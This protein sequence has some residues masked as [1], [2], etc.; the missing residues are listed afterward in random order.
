[1]LPFRAD[2]GEKHLARVFFLERIVHERH[3]PG[4]RCGRA[5]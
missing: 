3:G 5:R 2:P 4:R 1:V